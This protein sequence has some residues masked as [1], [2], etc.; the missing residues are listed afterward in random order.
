VKQ[1]H[2]S[3]KEK[4]KILTLTA[5]GMGTSS[6]AAQIKRHKRTVRNFLSQPEAK[7]A[8][9]NILERL[10]RQTLANVSP[11]NIEKSTLIQKITSAAIMIDKIR[12][13]RN[14]PTQIHV[15]YLLDA[16]AAIKEMRAAENPRLQLPPGRVDQKES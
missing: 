8:L 5:S 14:E 3:S 10:C 15:S 16:V 6:V 13:L 1:K 7:E 9:D 4:S 2:L 12:L 11:E